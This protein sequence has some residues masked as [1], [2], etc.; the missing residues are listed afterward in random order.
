M[1]NGGDWRVIDAA[2]E[3]LA[4]REKAA[5]ASEEKIPRWLIA[6]GSAAIVLGVAIAIWVALP[7]GGAAVDGSGGSGGALAPR[8]V[9]DVAGSARPSSVGAAG[10][11]VI[12]I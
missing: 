5:A 12:D 10:S 9:V 4:P 6:G 8:V 1:D 7:A 2:E 11:I 3:E